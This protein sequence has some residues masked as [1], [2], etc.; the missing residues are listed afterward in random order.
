MMAGHKYSKVD[1]RKMIFTKGLSSNSRPRD[2][3][4]YTRG[5]GNTPR[6]NQ[7]T[8]VKISRDRSKL[9]LEI[10]HK[11]IDKPIENRDTGLWEFP[12]LHLTKNNTI[13]LPKIPLDREQILYQ[14]AYK[15]KT[16]A[17]VYQSVEKG[18]SKEGNVR[19]ESG[20]VKNITAKEKSRNV[21]GNKGISKQCLVF[22]EE[23]FT[24]KINKSSQG[25][26]SPVCDETS[27]SEASRSPDFNDINRSSCYFDEVIKANSPRKAV[28]RADVNKTKNETPKVKKVKAVS[29]GSDLPHNHYMLLQKKAREIYP[30]LE[31][32]RNYQ[33]NIIKNKANHKNHVSKSLVNLESPKTVSRI[34]IR[35]MSD[36]SR[37]RT[38]KTVYTRKKQKNKRLTR[39]EGNLRSNNGYVDTKEGL[40]DMNQ[41]RNI[42]HLLDV[43]VHTVQPSNRRAVQQ[44]PSN[45]QTEVEASNSQDPGIQGVKMR[46]TDL[47]ENDILSMKPAK[48]CEETVVET[49]FKKPPLLRQ[50]PIGSNRL[51]VILDHTEFEEGNPERKLED[52]KVNDVEK[53]NTCTSLD[54]NMAFKVRAPPNSRSTT[55]ADISRNIQM[56]GVTPPINPKETDSQTDREKKHA[57]TQITEVPEFVTDK[58][59]D[60]YKASSS[61]TNQTAADTSTNQV[62]A[63]TSTNQTAAYTSTNQFM[64]KRRSLEKQNILKKEH[65][66]NTVKT[67]K[68][69]DFLTNKKSVTKQGSQLLDVP[70]VTIT[71]EGKRPPIFEGE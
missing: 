42:S 2:P 4:F 10:K 44:Q 40:L 48:N 67:K 8:G 12:D 58:Q 1:K 32:R 43:K 25:E 7:P 46:S 31:Y 41:Q 52:N 35:S 27:I 49:K 63:Y 11:N 26:L 16:P 56:A 64:T 68:E 17:V 14:K 39:S 29:V 65:Q 5:K 30:I 13:I 62:T 21:T 61:S 33:E 54:T 69:S 37:Y 36:I 57:H 71:S 50:K 15:R 53:S 47:S 55:L 6:L 51:A 70:R 59:T 9:I 34:E 19:E 24:L 28:H 66:T 23:V 45:E 60:T 20:E 38:N 18:E 3:V 22:E